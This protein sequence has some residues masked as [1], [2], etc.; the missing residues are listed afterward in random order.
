MRADVSLPRWLSIGLCLV[1]T[2]LVAGGSTVAA[3]PTGPV[4]LNTWSIVAADP[5]TGDVGVAGATCLPLAAEAL[6]ALAPGKGAAVAQALFVVDNRNLVFRLLQ[7]GRSASEIVAEVTAP[8]VDAEYYRRQ[9]G[10]VTINAGQ[11]QVAAYTGMANLDWAGHVVEPALAVSVQGNILAGEQV[12]IDALAA[13]RA[14]DIGPVALPD[15]L[16]RALEA[17]SA[18]GGDTRCNEGG[19]QQTATAAFIL[20]ARGDQPAFAAP[21]LGRGATDASNAPWLYLSVVQQP[22]TRN[23]LL[24]LREQYDTWRST[25]LPPCPTCNLRP[26][27]VPAGA[28]I[29]RGE[30][31][32]NAITIAGFVV[33]GIALAWILWLRRQAY[34]EQRQID[35][36]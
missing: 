25:H 9:Y 19:V 32:W 12:V 8:G 34:A 2:L 6:A 27:P 13:F 29:L 18:A 21:N 14:A 30:L 1:L 23:P 16:M 31:L 4:A 11:A 17:G 26:I 24:A 20:V 10:V 3:P 28:R 22:R 15:R 33:A 7:T 36:E 5:V 35:S